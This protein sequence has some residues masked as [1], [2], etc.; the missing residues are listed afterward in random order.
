MNK[1]NMASQHCNCNFSAGI[2]YF[3]INGRFNK[4][5]R[6]SKLSYFC[7]HESKSGLSFF[8]Q[9]GRKLH[10]RPNVSM[11]SCALDDAGGPDDPEDVADQ[12]REESDQPSSNGAGELG[13]VF[14]CCACSRRGIAD[15]CMYIVKW[16]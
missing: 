7:R 16:V 3:G 8:H 5:I 13:Q 10:G 4:N 9:S 6:M 2:Q 12:G 11:I 15:V 14:C 1:I